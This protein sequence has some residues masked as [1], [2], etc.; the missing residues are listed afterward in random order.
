MSDFWIRE[1]TVSGCGREFRYPDYEIQFRSEFSKGGE[2]SVAIVELY[3]LTRETEHIFKVGE[4]LTLKAGYQGDIGTV[5]LGEIRYARA[6]EEGRDRV[7][8]IEVHDTSAA[9]QGMEISESYVPGTTGSQILER[10]ISMSGLEKGKV[11]LVRDAVYGEGRNEDGT[12]REVIKRIAEDCGAEP[13]ITD[14][15]IHILPP[16]GSHDEA[17]LLSPA[18]GLIGSPN[19]IESDGESGPLWEVESL[20][21]YR[22]RAGTLVQVESKQ[23]NGLFA[24]ESGS[25]VSDGNEFKTIMQLAEPKL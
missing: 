17:V 12:I 9:Y 23:V 8:E 3:N 2:P 15:M 6:F 25:H 10:L 21:N 24:V 7:C 18:T 14:G 13:T 20:L 4:K 22:I 16:Y 5:L 19:L 11:Q 1:T